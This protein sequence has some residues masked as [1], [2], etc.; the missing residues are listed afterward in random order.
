MVATN[1]NDILHRCVQCVCYVHSADGLQ[2]TPFA[3]FAA[4]P[5]FFSKGDFS[6]RSV[7]PSLAPAM[8]IVVPSN[9]ERLLY[10]LADGDCERVRSWMDQS[11]LGLPLEGLNQDSVFMARLGATF[12][13]QRASDDEI[14]GVV[15]R[16]VVYWV[17]PRWLCAAAILLMRP[18]IGI[19]GPIES[20]CARTPRLDSMLRCATTLWQG[21]RLCA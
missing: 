17:S 1:C 7:V 11:K 6:R 20:V 15:S 13:S 3:L 9:F 2:F 12:T 10:F 5:R 21:P 16:Y 19:D 18:S 4:A 8:D 14:V